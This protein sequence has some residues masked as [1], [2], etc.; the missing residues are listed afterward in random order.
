MALRRPNLAPLWLGSAMTGLLPETFKWVDYTWSG[1]EPAQWTASIQSFMDLQF[2]GKMKPPEDRNG[3]KFISRED[4]W[5]L[6]YLTETESSRYTIPHMSP[7]PPF[8]STA[9]KSATIEVRKHAF[10]GHSLVYRHWVRQNK[11]EQSIDDPG[12]TCNSKNI[13]AQSH[14]YRIPIWLSQLPKKLCMLWQP[15]HAISEWTSAGDSCDEKLS[16]QATR[17]V[18]TWSLGDG[19][20]PED[21]AMWEHEWLDGLIEAVNGEDDED[22]PYQSDDCRTL[23]S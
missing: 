5:R 13:S 17:D 10:C 14:A 19:V 8:G 18:F 21:L 20:K 6:L 16:E 23:P 7:F 2:S 4:E 3:Q 12:T 9:L 15:G 22:E 1:M 11:D